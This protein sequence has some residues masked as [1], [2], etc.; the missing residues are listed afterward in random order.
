M[1]VLI[2]C[3]QLDVGYGAVSVLRDVSFRVSSG[4]SLLIIGHNGAGKSTLLRTLM[5]VQPRLGGEFAVAGMTA[6]KVSPKALI[7]VGIRYLGQGNRGFV[8]LSV[9]QSRR[10]LEL[11]YGVNAWKGDRTDAGRDKRTIGSLSYG[12]RRLE[13]LRL[14][15]AGEPILYLLDEPF[16]GVDAANALE[17]TAWIM[18]ERLRGAGFVVVEQRFRPILNLFD[19]VLVTRRGLVSY[20]GP[21]KFLEDDAR[22]GA[23]YL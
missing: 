22:M 6:N 8:N 19:Q 3:K 15:A 17:L 9:G 4:E 23:T 16:A 21:T 2:E 12:Q 10:A 5:G 1:K 20:Y 11:L 14:L 18:K 7:S 13:A